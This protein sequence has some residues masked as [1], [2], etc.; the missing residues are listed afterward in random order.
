MDVGTG[1]GEVMCVVTAI[2]PGPNNGV[3]CFLGPIV[4]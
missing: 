3:H 1:R 2:V 4:R